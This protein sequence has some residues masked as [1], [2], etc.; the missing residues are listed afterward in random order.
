MI[1]WICWKLKW[2]WV[3]VNVLVEQDA[4]SFDR[5]V[6]V[7]WWKRGTMETRDESRIDRMP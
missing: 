3:P 7:T 1:E 2:G 5:F 6:T 4:W